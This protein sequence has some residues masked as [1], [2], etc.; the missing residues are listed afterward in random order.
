MKKIVIKLGSNTGRLWI[1]EMW[2]TEV[3]VHIMHLKKKNKN[4]L[5]WFQ[6]VYLY[7]SSII[8]D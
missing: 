4:K 2:E 1:L 8:M 6:L 3:I 7:I 5:A